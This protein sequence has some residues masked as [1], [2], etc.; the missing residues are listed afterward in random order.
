MHEIT[1]T[2]PDEAY[3]TVNEHARR[4]GFA[5]TNDYLSDLVM[6][7]VNNV[8]NDPDNY[9]RLF[10]PAVLAAIDKSARDI[11]DGKGMTSS[12]VDEYLASKRAEWLKNHAA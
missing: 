12:Q 7:V 6:S 4:V 3:A 10:T 5:G 11:K 1:I 9:D 2:I 8:S